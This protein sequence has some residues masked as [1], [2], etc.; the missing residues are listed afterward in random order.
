MYTHFQHKSEGKSVWYQKPSHSTHLL[1]WLSI[2]NT[3]YLKSN[4][5]AK[6]RWT[7]QQRFL[8]HIHVGIIFDR[9]WRLRQSRSNFLQNQS[10]R[11]CIVTFLVNIIGISK[12]FE[13][14]SS[15]GPSKI[16]TC[17]CKQTAEK[18]VNKTEFCKQT[19]RKKW[20]HGFF[21]Y[22]SYNPW[23]DLE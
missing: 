15:L 1:L 10:F 6:S 22:A 17:K 23:N 4:S 14:L 13:R 5:V 9:E 12:S 21:S 11:Q 19:D 7:Y 18:N 2:W 16:T 20:H 8:Q 3:L